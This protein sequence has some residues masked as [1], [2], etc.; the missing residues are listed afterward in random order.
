MTLGPFLP[1]FCPPVTGDFSV[2]YPHALRRVSP[3]CRPLALRAVRDVDRP[4]H[5]RG[6]HADRPDRA[7]HARLR[8][9]RL[10]GRG[11]R[12]IRRGN[13]RRYAGCDWPGTRPHTGPYVRSQSGA[14]RNYSRHERQPRLPRG[15]PHR[16]RCLRLVLLKGSYRRHH[17][18]CAHDGRGPAQTGS[19]IARSSAPVR[20]LFSRGLVWRCAPAP[21]G[22]ARTARHTRSTDRLFQ[23]R[24]QRLG[25]GASAVW[26]GRRRGHGRSRSRRGGRSLE[27]RS[28]TGRAADKRRP[29]R[30]RRG[31]LDLDRRRALCRLWS[32]HDAHRGHRNARHQRLRAP[33]H[34]QPDQ[35]V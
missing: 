20:R 8:P 7:R 13:T 32:P 33:D 6:V 1:R 11:D 3:L 23:F 17:A 18:H 30:H 15:S 14:H 21:A 5:G 16:R 19:G 28:G 2:A 22:H 9:E 29:Q 31:H 24:Q 34:P 25:A 10:S 26:N 27:R 35:L 4:R 12:H